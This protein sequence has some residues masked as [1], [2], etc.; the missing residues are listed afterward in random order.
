MKGKFLKNTVITLCIAGLGS[1]ANAQKVTELQEVSILAP[2]AIKI[3]GKN[4]EWKES[5]F[6]VNK[7]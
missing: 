2:H 3:D 7:R 6:S 5:D 1:T 4:F